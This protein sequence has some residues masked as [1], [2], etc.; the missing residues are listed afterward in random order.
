M[1]DG[2]GSTGKGTAREL[3]DTCL[4]VFNGDAQR[5]Y[6][7]TLTAQALTTKGEAPSEQRSNLYLCSHAFVDDFSP[8]EPINNPT[9]RQYTGGNNITAARKHKGDVIFKFKGQVILLCN[10]IWTPME[11]F[12]G[13]DR[14]RHAG[15]SCDI[16]FVSVPQG[17]NESLKDKTVK[18]N[19]PNMFSEF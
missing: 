13:A 12:R 6:T 3:I 15:L 17:P 10:G 8:E 1:D 16:K 4:G 14:R 11:R 2:S 9:L 19:L 7:C 5:G 18:E